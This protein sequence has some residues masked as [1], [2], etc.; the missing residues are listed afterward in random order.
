MEVVHRPSYVLPFQTER[1]AAS[2]ETLEAF[3]FLLSVLLPCLCRFTGSDRCPSCQ[4]VSS[5]LCTVKPTGPKECFG[6]VLDVSGGINGSY[7]NEGRGELTERFWKCQTQASPLRL[8]GR[9][10][11][12]EEWFILR[13]GQIH[14]L[15]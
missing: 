4:E 11:G 1:C 15:A 3:V 9:K 8:M 12:E 10:E 6:G 5:G 14:L 2:A 7:R 13:R